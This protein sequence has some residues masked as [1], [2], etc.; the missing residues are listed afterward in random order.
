MELTRTRLIP[1][2]DEISSSILYDFGGKIVRSSSGLS[3]DQQCATPYWSKTDRS[4][5]FLNLCYKF[6]DGVEVNC[7]HLQC[8]Q[9][10]ASSGRNRIN[11]TARV[12]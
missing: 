5:I 6:V 12:T 7:L 9:S 11:V 1:S 8:I 3:K 2:A 10:L 4:N